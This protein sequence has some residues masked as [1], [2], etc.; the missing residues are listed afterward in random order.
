MSTWA[1]IADTL[2]LTGVEVTESELL[3]AEGLIELCSGVHTSNT[4]LLSSDLKV[5][6][7]AT[8]YQAAYLNQ[9]AGV[10]GRAGVKQLSQDGVA[11]VM[12]DGDT[13]GLMLSPLAHLALRQLSWHRN[14]D[15][16]RVLRVRRGAPYIPFEAAVHA[17]LTDEGGDA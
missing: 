7:H 9:Q 1:N 16:D 13:T 5:L 8:A 15:G 14:H 2:T 4:Q 11:V 3:Q 6:K 12:N 17:F 10:F